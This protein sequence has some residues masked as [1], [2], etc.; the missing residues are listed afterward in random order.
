MNQRE[1]VV[2]TILSVLKSKGIDYQLG[3]ETPVSQ[4]KDSFKAETIAIVAA[5][6]MSGS[7]E[8]SADAKAKYHTID[9]LRTKYVPGLVDNWVRKFKPFNGGEKYEAKN[10]GSR[11]GSQDEQIKAMRN[12][13]KCVADPE[14]KAEIQLAIDARM[15]EIKPNTTVEIN[16]DALPEHLRHLVG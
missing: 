16:V 10:P 2:N 12:L 3:G 13:L 11:S 1:G 6:F 8:M 15:A 9:L 14:T 4:Y 7:I 5:G